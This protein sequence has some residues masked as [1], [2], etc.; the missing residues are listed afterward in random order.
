MGPP[1]LPLSRDPEKP[2]RQVTAE[3]KHYDAVCD[4]ALHGGAN[5]LA[6]LRDE[7]IARVSCKAMGAGAH[8]STV[9]VDVAHPA[10]EQGQLVE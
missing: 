6:P 5:P 1:F 7:A 8:A 3:A 9:R 4:C 2:S 10:L